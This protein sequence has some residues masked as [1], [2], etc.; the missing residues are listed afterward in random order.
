M[1][2]LDYS[3]AVGCY[4]RSIL[5][6]PLES[7]TYANRA[8]AYLKMGDYSSVVADADKAIS[9]K[10]GYLKV[11]HRRG[12]AYAA[13]KQHDKAIKDFLYI[14][15]EQPDNKEVSNDLMDSRQKIS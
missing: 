9:L 1:K 2:A 6:D 8:M 11:H 13:L 4:S 10:P 7:A 12:K 3:E 5:L 15:Q 14:L